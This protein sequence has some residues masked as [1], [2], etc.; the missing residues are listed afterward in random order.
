M[1]WSTDGVTWTRDG[2]APAISQ[3]TFPIAGR[4]W[5]AAII[6]RDGLVQYYLE[7]GGTGG[8]GTNVYRAVAELP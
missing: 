7:I 6:Y 8:T 4:S 5:D 2:D 3:E 1:A